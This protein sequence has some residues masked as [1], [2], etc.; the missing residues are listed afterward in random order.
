MSHEQDEY[1]SRHPF[2]PH[3]KSALLNF[4][5]IGKICLYHSR[6]SFVFMCFSAYFHI[7]E[8]K[9]VWVR[10]VRLPFHPTN[11]LHTGSLQPMNRSESNLEDWFPVL[12][13]CSFNFISN[14]SPFLN[15]KYHWFYRPILTGSIPASLT[16]FLSTSSFLV[17]ENVAVLPKFLLIGDNSQGN[18]SSLQ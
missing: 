10:H 13:S 1:K 2:D 6:F 16:Y 8:L 7:C 11:R 18:F 12:C 9:S 14:Q 5:N 3:E 4:E 17:E 15:C